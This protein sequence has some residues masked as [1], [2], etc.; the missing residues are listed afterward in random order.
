MTGTTSSVRRHA[1]ALILASALVGTTFA[2]GSGATAASTDVRQSAAVKL[3]EAKLKPSG[4]PNGS[5]QANFRMRRHKVCASVEWRKIGDPTAAHIHK[6]SDG[7]VVVD[8]TGSVT[9]GAKCAA[10]GAKKIKR[11]KRHPKRYYFNVHNAAYPSG[12]IQGVLR[13]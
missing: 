13:R 1:V 2:P 6:R 3:L 8:L 7:S 10:A 11:I 12:A 5:G 4:D 9:S